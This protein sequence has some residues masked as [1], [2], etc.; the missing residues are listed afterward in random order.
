VSDH[1]KHI[2]IFCV[3]LW[4][5]SALI[6][7]PTEAL[8]TLNS[9]QHQP[10]E[11][12][13]A[14]VD[15]KVNHLENPGMEEWTSLHDI[16]EVNTHRTTEQ[17]VWNA[18]LPSPVIEG[19]YSKGLQSRAIDPNH[20]AEASIWRTGGYP[21]NPINLTLKFNWYVDQIATPIDSDYFRLDMQFG[22][23][24]E[25]HLY[26]YF[27]CSDSTK[28]NLSYA[29][30]YFFID[31]PIQT[32]NTF[33]RNIT[34]DFFNAV[35]YY[36]QQ[37]QLFSFDLRT[38][39]SN[40]SRVF[41]DDLWLLNNTVLIGG[42]IGNGDFEGGAGWSQSTNQD[43][44]DI[45]QSAVSQEGDWSLNATTTSVGNQSYLS[46]SWY[47]DR[48]I[49]TLNPDIFSF[50][51]RM[52]KF[53]GPNE[54]TFA[55]VRVSGE[56]ESESLSVYYVLAYGDNTNTIAPPENLFINVTGFNTT[57]QWHSFDR[58]IWSDIISFYNTDFMIIDEIEINIRADGPTSEV[59]IL[60]DD[61]HFVS[62]AMDDMG[63]ED[64]GD[65]GDEVHTWST[66][67]NPPPK[68]TVTDVAHSGAKAAN[69]TVVDSEL[70]SGERRFENRLV[71][72][73]TD[74]WL[75]FFWRIND[76]SAN[77]SNLMYLEV[78]FDSGESLA[79][80]FANHSAVP[81]GNGFDEYII[82]PEANTVD[83]WINFQR[84]LFDDFVT[85]FG[86]E[87]D[88]KI[89]EFYLFAK[90]DSGG[91]FEVLFDDVYLYND[92]APAISG[93]QLTTPVANRDVNVTATVEDLSSFTVTLYYRIDN[94]TWTDVA[95]VDTGSGFNATIPGQPF[96]TE[97]NYYIEA[98]DEF[99]QISV[100]NE[101]AYLIPS[102]PTPTDYT[103]LIVGVIIVVVVIGVVVVYYFVIRPK[104]SSK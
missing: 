44:A 95:M 62:A 51:W 10:A 17:Y 12:D 43:P 68:F 78:Y 53:N 41:V 101:I 70:W 8:V 91:R 27:G 89:T 88:T 66:Y 75:D 35:G 52:D 64:Q 48:H 79:Y 100:T 65:V 87:P 20:P 67:Y 25:H 63:Y 31:K 74:L 98:V 55:Y 69:L 90:A 60:F 38:Y 76:D 56:N 18:Q 13:L 3:S 15:W 73:E 22:A 26:Y 54:D 16:D 72:E 4:L 42:S 49:S 61:M 83:S 103:P 24:G 93:V 6:T 34:E 32:W 82:L 96:D 7:T 85:A 59:S 92:P 57:S 50:Q 104:Q 58:S 2:A 5:L 14:R 11:T 94:G 47:P 23:S 40:Y 46:V 1:L 86:T 39:S 45:S 19:L 28:T 36:P 71:N 77:E 80:I 84:N 29:Y 99:S 21:D 102:E 37:Y 81:T 33:D 30:K 97:V 9:S